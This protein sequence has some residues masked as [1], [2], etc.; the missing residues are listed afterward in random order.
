MGG[1]NFLHLLPY[2]CEK[3]GIVI[4]LPIY[5]NGSSCG[6]AVLCWLITQQ[7]FSEAEVCD[8]KFYIFRGGI[9][10]RDFPLWLLP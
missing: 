7:N 9:Q 10:F 2:S 3:T 8:S 4:L 5:L 6:Y 1:V